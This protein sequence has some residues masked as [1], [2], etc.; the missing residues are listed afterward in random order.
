VSASK[1]PD[2][3]VIQRITDEMADAAVAILR[4][5]KPGAYCL[6]LVHAPQRPNGDL[7]LVAPSDVDWQTMA[8]ALARDIALKRQDS[9][10]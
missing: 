6:I 5:F 1:A 2:P 9:A 7:V 10:R 3:L 8:D 4:H